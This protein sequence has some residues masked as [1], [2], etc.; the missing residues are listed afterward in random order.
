MSKI[1]L[2]TFWEYFCKISKIPFCNLI[3]NACQSSF[4]RSLC[5]Q[6][7]NLDHWCTQ[8]A[9]WPEKND[10]LP[11]ILPSLLFV[12]YSVCFFSIYDLMFFVMKRNLKK[13]FIFFATPTTFKK[14][15]DI[16]GNKTWGGGGGGLYFLSI[17]CLKNVCLLHLLHKFK[18]ASEYFYH[19]SKHYQSFEHPKHA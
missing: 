17:I 13:I 8:F 12:A 19:G 7:N 15:G 3:L 5:S 6:V 11:E 9:L 10:L 1:I 18:S 16:A 2:I 14:Y 4:Q